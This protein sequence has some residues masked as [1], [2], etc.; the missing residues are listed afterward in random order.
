M[1]NATI[2]LTQGDHFFM[3]CDE[4]IRQDQLQP[5]GMN[6]LCGL[7]TMQNGYPRTDNVNLVV[8][9]LKCDEVLPLETFVGNTTSDL[10]VGCVGAKEK[11]VIHVSDNSQYFNITKSAVFQDVIFDGL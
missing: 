7:R 1:V 9:A 6:V 2:W 4:L 10:K 11:P 5:L 8:K 3:Y